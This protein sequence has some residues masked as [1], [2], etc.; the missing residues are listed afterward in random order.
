MTCPRKT[1]RTKCWKATKSRLAK[2]PGGTTNQCL[3]SELLALTS[4]E[5]RRNRTETNKHK[6]P[7]PKKPMA[8]LFF[9]FAISPWENKTLFFSL[10]LKKIL[11]LKV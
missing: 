11:S 8:G 7:V 2:F 10:E 9:N 3:Q 5:N 1:A 6:A 4:K